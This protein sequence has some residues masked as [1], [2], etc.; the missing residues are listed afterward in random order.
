[1]T[2]ALIAALG[3]TRRY[4]SVINTVATMSP[5]DKQVQMAIIFKIHREQDLVQFGPVS[6]K[7]A[8]KTETSENTPPGFAQ[9]T[10]DNVTKTVSLNCLVNFKNAENANRDKLKSQAVSHF[11]DKDEMFK[12]TA[13]LMTDMQRAKNGEIPKHIFVL[14]D[15]GEVQHTAAPIESGETRPAQQQYQQQQQQQQRR[16]PPPPLKVDLSELEDKVSR[17]CTCAL[18]VGALVKD[19]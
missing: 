6:A 12:Q 18:V 3:Q 5:T 7:E 8:G 17:T 4:S 16:L 1:M 9:V 13:L 15:F 11:A 19:I 14:E 10:V 2:T